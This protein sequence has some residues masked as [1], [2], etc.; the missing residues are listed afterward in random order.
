MKKEVKLTIPYRILSFQGEPEDEL[1]L[2]AFKGSTF[3]G[4]LGRT[5]RQALC[6]LKT[7]KNCRECPLYQSCYYAYIFE[8]IP[9][10]SKPLPFNFHKYPSIPHPYVL[11]PPEEQKTVYQKGE[12]FTLQILLF[13]KA[14]EYVPHFVLA[15]QLAGEHGVGKGNKKFR[16][17]NYSVSTGELN[18][19]IEEP[20]KEA[21]PPDQELTLDFATPL[22]LVY[23]GKL[24]KRLEFHYLIRNLLRRVTSIYYFHC[25][26]HLPQI[27]VDSL[28]GFAEKVEIKEENLHWMDWERY[29]YRQGRRMLLGGLVGRV[30]FV[31]P[32]SP[33]YSIL[34][35]GE[36][37]H[38][39]KNTSFGLGKYKILQEGSPYEDHLPNRKA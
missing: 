3:R 13:G 21:S 14:T 6:A 36:L 29:S 30:T 26:P 17:N 12:A 7:F 15:L 35:A 9:D 33:F 27:P 25:N 2:P 1:Y 28:I 4:V 37:L 10:P 38:L 32:L 11:E 24:V 16:I 39:G 19:T 20:V 18:I 8:T 23:Q 31:G 5:L 22:R 34:K